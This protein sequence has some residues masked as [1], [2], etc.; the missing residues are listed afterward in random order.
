MHRWQDEDGGA[1]GR[2]Q[3]RVGLLRA[4]LGQALIVA[5]IGGALAARSL[6]P[7]AEPRAQTVATTAGQ[8]TALPATAISARPNPQAP[9]DVA[10]VGRRFLTALSRGDLNEAWRDVAAGNVATLSSRKLEGAATAFQS[11]R[12]RAF[13]ILFWQAG[14]PARLTF[15]FDYERS[16]I[17]EGRSRVEL[18]LVQQ[19]GRWVVTDLDINAWMIDIGIGRTP[20]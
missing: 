7:N 12:A 3:R 15:S 2:G 14:D 17:G 8:P 1:G 18:R 20:S 5:V 10:T 19:N 9:D 11:T 4:V 6:L 16:D 13:R